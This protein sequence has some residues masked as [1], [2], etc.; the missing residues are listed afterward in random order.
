MKIL[1]LA[2]FAKVFAV[3]AFE[4]IRL[5]GVTKVEPMVSLPVDQSHAC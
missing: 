3:P 1:G 2:L 4:R 5:L